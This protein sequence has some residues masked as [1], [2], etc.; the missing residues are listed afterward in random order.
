M[1]DH[2]RIDTE[3]DPKPRSGAPNR[4]LI[5]D[6]LVTAVNDNIHVWASWCRDWGWD[7]DEIEDVRKVLAKALDEVLG[8]EEYTP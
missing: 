1:P 5:V 3:L 7:K 6:K 2:E 4:E 8:S